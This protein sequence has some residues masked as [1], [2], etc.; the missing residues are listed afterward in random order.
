MPTPSPDDPLAGLSGLSIRDTKTEAPGGAAALSSDP[1]ADFA[2][3]TAPP[4][5]AASGHAVDLASDL[6]ML[7][8]P[9]PVVST[10]AVA[11]TQPPVDPL[12]SLLGGFTPDSGG[13]AVAS[14]YAVP[15]PLPVGPV[16]YRQNVAV[17]GWPSGGEMDSGAGTMPQDAAKSQGKLAASAHTNKGD[18]FADLLDM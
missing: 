12:Q 10:S 3:V 2:S 18:A 14:S 8:D 6:D 17:P 16:Q 7:S 11:S 4:P 9:M 1:F 5:V 15:P 13:A